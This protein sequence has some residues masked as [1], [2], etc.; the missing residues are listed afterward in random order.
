MLTSFMLKKSVNAHGPPTLFLINFH[1][2]KGVALNI[3]VAILLIPA[4]F[5]GA[6]VLMFI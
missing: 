2:V 5:T 1:N 3:Y 4:G 6:H